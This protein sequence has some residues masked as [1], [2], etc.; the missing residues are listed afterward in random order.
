MEHT[1]VIPRDEL[2]KSVVQSNTCLDVKDGRVLVTDKV[3]GDDLVFGV[4]QDT[5]ERTIGVLFDGSH[6]GVIRGG[7]TQLDR[8]V[9]DRDVRSRDTE[10]HAGE[11]S[12]QGRDDFTDSLGGTGGGGDN[13]L[14]CATTGTPV[15][16]RGAI[17]RFLGGR[18]RVD[19]GHETLNNAKLVVDDFGERRQT[20]GGAR[21]VGDDLHGRVV[22]VQVDTTDKH[23]SIRRGSR[24]DNF[25]STA[26]QVS[27]GL[28]H[29]SEDT[30][31]LDNVVGA[32]RAPLDLF[33][34]HGVEDS[35]LA[36]VDDKLAGFVLDRALEL[37]VGRVVLHHVD[38]HSPHV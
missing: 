28:V 30:G 4:A 10:S 25:F 14:A 15:L 27:L 17:D 29:G 31:G 26:N 37:A 36:A 34:L 38:L 22:L 12:V 11:F 24:D 16:S 32:S 23:G 6:N 7:F 13:V 3:R 1:V 9:D 33:G 35:D 19:S 21:G 2:D 18:D 8:Q 5:L 20:V